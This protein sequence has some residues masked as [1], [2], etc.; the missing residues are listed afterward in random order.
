MEFYKINPRGYSCNVV[1]NGGF[2]FFFS[3]Y[4]GLFA[5]AERDYN[6]YQRDSAAKEAHFKLIYGNSHLIGGSLGGSL[7]ASVARAFVKKCEQKYI[8]TKVVFDSET[9]EELNNT[10][11]FEVSARVRV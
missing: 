2:Y 1:F 3:D 7:A 11:V 9:Y 6:N 8:A 10:R 4:A 5:I